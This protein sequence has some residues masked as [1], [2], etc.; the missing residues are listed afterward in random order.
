MWCRSCTARRQ[1]A[2]ARD[3]PAHGM[4]PVSIVLEDTEAARPMCRCGGP[5]DESGHTFSLR[6]MEWS[7]KRSEAAQPS[8][9]VRRVK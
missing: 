6:H 7:W 2:I 9:S 8:S 1:E 4:T 5:A 3:L